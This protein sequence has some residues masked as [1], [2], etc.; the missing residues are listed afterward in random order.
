MMIRLLFF[1]VLILV[2][3]FGFAWLADPSRR[4]LHRLAGPA[5]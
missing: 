1:V 5:H 4:S 3:G 2:L